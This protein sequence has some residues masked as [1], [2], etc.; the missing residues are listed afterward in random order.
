MAEVEQKLQ[1][2]GQPTDGIIV[3]ATSPRRSLGFTPM[4]RVPKPE[5][6]IGWR[7]GRSSSSPRKRRNQR[8]PSPRTMWS[9]SIRSCRSGTLAMW[10]PTTIVAL[11]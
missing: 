3:A 2:S 10:P 8:T 5:A 11:G 6:I 7:K 4:L 1:P 9:A